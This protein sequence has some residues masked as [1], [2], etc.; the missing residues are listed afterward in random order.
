MWAVQMILQPGGEPATQTRG[1]SA[2]PVSLSLLSAKAGL[3]ARQ[4]QL[5]AALS[6]VRYRGSL[7]RLRV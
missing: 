4:R 6:S 3:K 1:G 2:P 7:M 5:K